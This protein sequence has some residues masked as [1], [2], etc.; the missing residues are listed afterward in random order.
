MGQAVKTAPL[1]LDASA[2]LAVLFS[3]PG[4]EAV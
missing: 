1:I 4:W 3:E 2:L